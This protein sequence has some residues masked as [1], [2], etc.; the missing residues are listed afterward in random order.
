[1]PKLQSEEVHDIVNPARGWYSL[2]P[3][4]VQDAI[5]ETE[6]RWYLKQDE[7]I[8]LVLLDMGAYREKILDAAAWKHIKA[9]LRFFHDYQKDVILRPV[10]D[11][12]GHG[13]EHEPAQLELVVRH[14]EQIGT[15]LRE[16][17]HSVFLFQ[18]LLIGSWGEMH[19]SK[20][21][22]EDCL[23]VLYGAIRPFLGEEIC[24][25]VRTPA[26]WRMLI[27][28][29]AYQENKYQNTGLFNDALFSS[30]TDMGTFGFM[31]KEAAGW[32][33]KW[34]RAEELAFETN[35]CA[36]LPYGG[37]VV[38]GAER[39]AA[40][41]ADEMRT[42]HLSYLNRGHD[43]RLLNHWKEG[44]PNFYEYVSDHMGYRFVVS[45][46]SGKFSEEDWERWILSFEIRNEGF[47]RCWQETELFLSVE[48][49]TERQTV[50]M[51]KD[52]RDWKAGEVQ[53]VSVI[54]RAMRGEVYLTAR[55]KKDGA[56]IIFANKNTD[57][58]LL[59]SLCEGEA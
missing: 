59:G 23:N 26:I 8:A 36:Q 13:S 38:W 44:Q 48:N 16:T 47:G 58:L 15:V 22:S 11:T 32:N 18:G 24:L 9:I 28:E 17:E 5:D 57:R 41:I 6:L 14:L 10:Y 27:P 33:Q 34:L 40:S 21:I 7:S 12:E 43:L 19:T 1:M 2:Y 45:C 56:A 35:I 46:P 29:T 54:L 3:F 39:T 52:L 53:T 55:R 51:K 4:A 37:E 20:F 30:E 42:I 25:A 49:E 50:A 31:S